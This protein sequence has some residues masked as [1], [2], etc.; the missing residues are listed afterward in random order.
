MNSASEPK[1][2]GSYR[3]GDIRH[4]FADISRLKAAGIKPEISLEAGL[5]RFCSWV[6]T[7]PIGDDLLDKANGE[8]KSRKLM[9]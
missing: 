6:A 1:A 7:Q 2:T 9:G 5:E 3:V 8:L 4:N